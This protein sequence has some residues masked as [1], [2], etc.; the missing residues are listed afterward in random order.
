MAQYWDPLRDLVALQ[1][2][3]NRLFEETAQRRA[4]EEG[5]DGSEIER[6]DWTP[7][8]DVYNR[9]EE[10]LIVIDLPGVSREA[11]D[12]SLNNDR[13][14]I[15]GER[16]TDTEQQ[17]QARTE[18]PFGTFLRKFGPLPPTVDQKSVS[19]EYK[20]GVLRVRLPKRREQKQRRVEIKVQ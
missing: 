16:V 7:A 9:D 12:I 10:Y 19:A 3:M 5:E 1:D 6:A 17:Q 15:R 13:L 11:L 14:V 4:R 20:D 2:R 8:A 18:R